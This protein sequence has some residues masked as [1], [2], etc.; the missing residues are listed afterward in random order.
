MTRLFLVDDH[1]LVLLGLEALFGAEPDLSVV[2]K[3]ETAA[4]ALRQI[5]SLAPDVVLLDLRLPDQS[6]IEVCRQIHHRW[7]KVQVLILTSYSDDEMVM[8]AIQAG[9]SGYALKQLDTAELLSAVRAVARGD[10]VLD[11][12]VT[13]RV[14]KRLRDAEHAAH[15]SAFVDLSDR[16]M[17][18]LQLVSRGM[19]NAEIADVLTLSVKTVGHHVST[20]LAKLE[21]GNRIEAA[22]FAVRND[23]DAFVAES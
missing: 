14:L 9:A 17:Q 23:I 22:T 8:A 2:G 15:A 11:A 4:S 12:S 20:I 16:E 13:R 18:I 1:A 5:E 21:L 7:P 10:A 19:T 3:A 6:G